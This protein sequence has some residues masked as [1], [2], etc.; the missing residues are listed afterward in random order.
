MFLPGFANVHS[1]AFQRRLRGAVQRR[2]PGHADTFW[3]WRERMYGLA[4]TLG[5]EALEAIARAVYAE[6]L[7]SGYTAVGEF[8][9]LHHDPD[10]APYA[11]PIATARAH[12]RAAAA[13]GIRVTLLWSAYALGGFDTPATPGQRRFVSRDLDAVRRAL[14][15]LTPLGDARPTH[16]RIGLAIHS[17]RAVPR[18]W[19]APLAAEARA[20]GLPLHVHASEQRIEVDACLAKHGTTPIALL[21]DEGVLGPATTI[22]HGTWADAADIGRLAASGATVALCPS[23]E[24]DLGDGMAPVAGLFRAGV[25]IAI[26]SDSHAVIDP[27]AELRAVEHWARLVTHERCVVADA[28]GAVAPALLAIGSANGYRALGLESCGD[29]IELDAGARALCDSDDPLAAALTS[30]HPGLVRHVD[31]A[32][33]RVVEDGRALGG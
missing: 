19:L 22:V 18:E 16:V 12:V 33:T 26:G 25:P 5:L 9:Y 4:N 6:C 2:D 24:G 10:G 13:V 32:G 27:F 30:G 29:R 20:R 3:S 14:D 31:V 15:L 1:H 28:T 23:T 21:D 8:H 7:E 11:D 17:V